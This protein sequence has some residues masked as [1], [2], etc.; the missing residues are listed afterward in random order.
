MKQ[1]VQYL[2]KNFLKSDSLAIMN[3]FEKE[4]YKKER[5]EYVVE[6]SKF[7]QKITEK[8]GKPTIEKMEKYKAENGANLIVVNLMNQTDS[9]LKVKR[10]DL[11]VTFYPDQFLTNPDKFLWYNLNKEPLINKEIAPLLRPTIKM[12]EEQ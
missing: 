7:F 2:I 3:S 9:S 5:I 8:Y 12:K 6:D 11:V 4:E 1:T 10:C